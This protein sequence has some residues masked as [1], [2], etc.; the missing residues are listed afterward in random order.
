MDFEDLDTYFDFNNL[1]VKP[2]WEFRPS[3]EYPTSA[4]EPFPLC[5]N[6]QDVFDHLSL[7]PIEACFPTDLYNYASRLIFLTSPFAD[8]PP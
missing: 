3:S 8:F 4:Y 6:Q 5:G 1:E 7:S 2:N